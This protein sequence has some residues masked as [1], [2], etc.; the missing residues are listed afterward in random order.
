[1]YLRLTMKIFSLVSILSLSILIGCGGGGENSSAVPANSGSVDGQGGSMARFSIIGDYLYTIS[2][3]NLQLYN[4]ATDPA[5]PSKYARIP[6]GWDIETLYSANNYLFI[7]AST[8]VYIFDNNDPSNPFQVSKFLHVQSCDPVVVSGQYAYVTLR[9]GGRCGQGGSRM[10]VLDLTDIKNPVMVKSYVM[11]NPKGLGVQDN[12]LFVC[13]DVAGLKVFNLADPLNPQL[14]IDDVSINCFDLI[15]YK[16]NL[17]VNDNNSGNL[18]ISDKTGILQYQYDP[19]GLTKVSS[20]IQ[21]SS[22][23]K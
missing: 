6:V 18:V 16:N 7:G 2:G 10:E 12:M 5:K 13:D 8:G 4:L 11:Q 1:M 9:G 19:V 14:G 3:K 23:V 22:V 17:V 15:P 21:N 20:I